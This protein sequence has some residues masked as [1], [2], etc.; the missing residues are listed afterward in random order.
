MIYSNRYAL[1]SMVISQLKAKYS[2]SILG[3]SWAVVNPLLIMLVITF[4]FTVVFKTE[5]KNFSFFVLSGIFPWIFFS[6]ALSEATVSFLNQQ[7][8]L[9]QFNL[10]R[11]IIPLSSMLA[12][13]LNF[14]IGWLV[15]YPLF[16]FFNPKIITLL[17]ILIVVFLLNLCFV[18]GLGLILS[19]ANVFIRDIAQLLSVLL[20]LW[21]W[22][23][24]VFYSVEM[25]PVK[26]RWICNLNPMTS[27]IIYYRE[28]VFA[29]TIPSF[30]VFIATFLWAVFS[31]IL[32]YW[33]FLR[34]E[35]GLLKRI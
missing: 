23:T 12:N 30:S 33:V 4:V 14:L 8:I 34:L 7:N 13:F 11:E 31:M 18:F 27:Y 24:P 22:L 17:P 2:G 26:F 20:M 6:N 1:W 25:V 29:G 32:G 10:S 5:I 9:R 19:V 3:I 16:L 28:V 35:S 15:I 21:L